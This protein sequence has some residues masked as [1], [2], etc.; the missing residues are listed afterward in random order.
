[1]KSLFKKI[2]SK[3]L[4]WLIAILVFLFI[5]IP[6][7]SSNFRVVYNRTLGAK[8]INYSKISSL[9]A[10]QST[11]F[12]KEKLGLSKETHNIKIKDKNYIENNF[13]NE[14]YFATTISNQ[15]GEVKFFSITTRK[16]NFNPKLKLPS[17]MKG[18]NELTL[19]KTKF[20]ELGYSTNLNEIK[21][22]DDFDDPKNQFA[23]FYSY[24]VGPRSFNYYER[25]YLGFMGD[26]KTFFFGFNDNGAGSPGIDVYDESNFDPSKEKI[27]NFKLLTIINTYGE[28][29]LDFANLPSNFHFGTSTD[30]A[31]T[32]EYE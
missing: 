22:V 24:D 20:S 9:K 12:F 27:K 23:D 15:E 25:Y 4:K 17:L 3:N 8:R 32:S 5:Q 26:Y 1:M 21:F 19:G 6:I 10:G 7:I 11:E 14:N 31:L 2:D 18:L 13:V 16:I 28:A 29:D 30:S